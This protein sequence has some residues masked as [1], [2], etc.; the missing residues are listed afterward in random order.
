MSSSNV[1]SPESI[2]GILN[3]SNS[4]NMSVNESCTG[5]SGNQQSFLL[6]TAKYLCKENADPCRQNDS[7]FLDTPPYFSSPGRLFHHL[8]H[9]KKYTWSSQ[10]YFVWIFQK[11][12]RTNTT[13]IATI[14]VHW[15]PIIWRPI[16]KCSTIPTRPFQ[17]IQSI[18]RVQES[19]RTMTRF[20]THQ[21]YHHHRLPTEKR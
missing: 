16:H 11:V 17:S 5:N 18:T 9:C 7:I 2:Q 14:S 15:Q 10:Q 12:S 19:T 3:I 8:N 1:C 13:A 6:P 21:S 4:Q 20:W